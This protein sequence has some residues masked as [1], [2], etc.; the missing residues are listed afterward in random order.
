MSRPSFKPT[1]E[2]RKQVYS[3]AGSGSTHEHIARVVGIRSPKTLRKHFRR[4]IARGTAEANLKLVAVACQMAAS[5]KYPVMTRMWLETM[6][7]GAEAPLA[8]IE[9]VDS[10]LDQEEDIA[11]AEERI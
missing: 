2:Q 11:D 6:G 4:E 1:K 7:G 8:D 9:E 5:G 3:L 10:G